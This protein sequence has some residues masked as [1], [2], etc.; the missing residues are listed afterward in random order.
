MGIRVHKVVGYGSRLATQSKLYREEIDD[1]TAENFFDWCGDNSKILESFCRDYT[2][3]NQ[4]IEDELKLQRGLWRH[5]TNNFKRWR[6]YQSCIF[7]PDKR[8]NCMTVFIP[9]GTGGWYRFDNTLDWTEETARYKQRDRVVWLTKSSGIFPYIGTY[10]RVRIPED[11]VFNE[12]FQ[13][14]NY[15]RLFFRKSVNAYI[16]DASF[17]HQLVG[18]W[19]DK[20]GPTVEEPLLSHLKN[21]WMPQLPFILCAFLL[22]LEMY[23]VIECA[24]SVL[25]KLRPV[26]YVY[27]S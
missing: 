26:L 6:P 16:C 4:S 8:R 22:F 21:D 14:E 19:D 9:P 7:K 1:F 11:H 18:W 15:D 3:F 23:D 5:D 24:H 10:R 12:T 13:Q 27:W 17:L 25:I 2:I 20:I